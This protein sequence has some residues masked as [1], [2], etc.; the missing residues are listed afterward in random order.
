MLRANYSK[1]RNMKRVERLFELLDRLRAR[2]TPVTADQLAGELGISPRSIYRDMDTLRAIGAPIE[3]EAGVGF[4]LLPGFLLPPLM[5]TEDEMDAL[6]LGAIWVRQRA[7]PALAEAA[8]TALAKI[9]A[10]L[11]DTS[12]VPGDVPILVTAAPAA[13]PADPASAAL[14]RQAVRQQRKIAVSYRDAQGRES[15]RILWPIAIAFFEEARILAAWCETRAAFRHFRLDRLTGV[16]LMDERYL[17]RRAR[18]LKRWR[19]QDPM[20][21][22]RS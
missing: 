2:R 4:R 9:S 11:P 7:D 12:L 18:L 3:G 13:V 19:E 8:G 1:A 22:L 17:E 21:G 14:L 5:L 20:T 16:R 15:R 6:A 10:V